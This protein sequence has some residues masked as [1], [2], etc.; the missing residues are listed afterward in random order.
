M[1][2]EAR[3]REDKDSEEW[4]PKVGGGSCRNITSNALQ[5]Y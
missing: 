1:E 3:Y 2:G 4:K 5:K